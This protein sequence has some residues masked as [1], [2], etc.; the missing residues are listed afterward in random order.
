MKET[1][2]EDPINNLPQI[3]NLRFTNFDDDRRVLTHV[4]ENVFTFHNIL[5]AL[6][7]DDKNYIIWK[8]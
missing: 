7:L 2:L 4:D 1:Q 6:N 3:V 5:V 8:H